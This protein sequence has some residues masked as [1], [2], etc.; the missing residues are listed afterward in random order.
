M[1]K[2]RNDSIRGQ[3][4]S[5]EPLMKGQTSGALLPSV[6]TCLL[7]HLVLSSGLGIALLYIRGGHTSVFSSPTPLRLSPRMGYNEGSWQ[8]PG[9][10]LGWTGLRGLHQAA[11]VPAPL[12]K[13]LSDVGNRKLQ[14]Y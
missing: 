2:P 1:G 9:P 7:Y 3:E 8:N 5:G 13:M 10:L 11:W 6:A 12:V 4:D 14:L